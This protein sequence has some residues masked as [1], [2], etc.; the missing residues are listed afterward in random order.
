MCLQLRSQ[1]LSLSG[2]GKERKRMKDS[3][4]RKKDTGNK[5]RKTKERPWERGWSVTKQRLCIATIILC[6]LKSSFKS[7]SS[8]R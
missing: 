5:K 3:G 6:S 8:T 1:G 4:K 2:I 7:H